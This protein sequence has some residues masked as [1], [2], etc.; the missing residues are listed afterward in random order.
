MSIGEITKDALRYPFSDWKKILVL[1]IFG[2]IATLSINELIGTV[3][4]FFDSSA[5]V[6]I[7]VLTIIGLLSIFIERGYQFRILKSSLNGMVELPKFNSWMSMLKDG[8]KLSIVTIVY[9][10]PFVLIYLVLK[11]PFVAILQLIFKSPI[12]MSFFTTVGILHLM[13]FFILFLFINIIL[14]MFMISIANMANNNGKLSAAFKFRQIT[15]KLS[16]VGWKNLIVWYV[17]T[18]FIYLIILFISGIIIKEISHLIIPS[19]GNALGPL[20]ITILMSLIVISYL[21]MYLYRSL[22]LLWLKK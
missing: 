16:S 3:Y 15:N 1:G 17:L 8:F 13:E 9:L 12:K 7:V 2:V 10:I 19:A 5:S 22:A 14:I 20:I 21:Y 6:S 11:G 4:L 18:E